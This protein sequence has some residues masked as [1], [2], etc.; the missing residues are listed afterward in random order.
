MPPEFEELPIPKIEIDED[1]SL[2]KDSSK[3]IEIDLITNDAEID[4]SLE[5]NENFEN[6]IIN[7]IKKN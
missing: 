6:S 4:N 3:N 2:N 1:N 5:K 7:Q